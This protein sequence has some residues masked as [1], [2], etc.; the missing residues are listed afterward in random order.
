MGLERGQERVWKRVKTGL[1][2]GQKRVL[3]GIKKESRQIRQ[4]GTAWNCR[5]LAVPPLFHPFLTIFAKNGKKRCKKWRNGKGKKSVLSSFSPR[6][7]FF[8]FLSSHIFTDGA[9]V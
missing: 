4:F 1:E 5:S 6:S 8:L 3:N 7:C 2:R 9:I